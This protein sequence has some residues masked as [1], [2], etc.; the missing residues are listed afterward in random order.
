VWIYVLGNDE[1]ARLVKRASD[2]DE[3][4]WDVLVEQFAGLVWSVV[5]AH[6]LFDA[7]AHDVFQ[8]V[9]LRCVEHLRRLRDPE[10]LAGWLATTTRHE[11]F[12]VTRIARRAQ[13]VADVPLGS[14]DDSGEDR[15]VE[16]LSDADEQAAFRRALELLPEQCRVLLRL[17]L[18]EPPL[19][20]DEISESLGIPR[21]SIGPTR[22]RCLERVRRLVGEPA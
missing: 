17:L 7:D 15:L 8:T 12:R 20:Y 19:S 5:R 11:C 18:S 22:Q 2:G 13:P 21:G 16:R 10:R 14:D 3:T 4:A 6:G 1:V 9:W